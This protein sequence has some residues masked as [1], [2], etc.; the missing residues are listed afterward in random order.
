MPDTL[1]Q[2]MLID[3]WNALKEKDKGEESQYDLKTSVVMKGKKTLTYG[4]L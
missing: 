2:D 4:Y 3:P 1:L